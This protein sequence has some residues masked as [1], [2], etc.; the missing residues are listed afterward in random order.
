[1]NYNTHRDP[2]VFPEYGRNI[3][4]MVD[5]LLTIP[6][7]ETR[8]IAAQQVVNLMAQQ[9]PQYRNLPEYMQKLWDHLHIMAGYKLD[10]DSEYP[11]PEKPLGYRRN[12]KKPEYPGNPPKYRFYGKSLE[13]AIEKAAEM[14]EGEDRDQ[15]INSLVSFMVL[16]YKIWNTEKVPDELII[17][18]L[19]ELSHGKIT[20]SQVPE[21]FYVPERP[22]Q[23]R[24][25]SKK[26]KKK[27][28]NKNKNY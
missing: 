16:S 5:H 22:V 15:L 26:K 10:V 2:L 12:P 27:Q 8:S 19:H 9:N 13:K 1:M 4:L 14:P 6:D 18:H 23:K 25:G 20:I 11:K 3:Q 28:N 17:K 21:V 7:K 24:T